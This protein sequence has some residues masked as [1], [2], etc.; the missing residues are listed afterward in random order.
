MAPP[1]PVNSLIVEDWFNGL[2]TAT[3]LV[4][5]WI[6]ISRKHYPGS[7]K[8]WQIM[9]VL[10]SYICSTMHSSLNWLYY[11][12]AIDDNELP[13][14][15]GL[16][17]SLT[18]LKV[19]IEGTGD[20]FFCLNIFMADCLFVWRC[21]I[22]WNR[23]WP[24]VVL[25]ILATLSGAVLAGFIVSDQVTALKSLEAFTVAKKSQQFVQLSTIY[26]SL[27]V[28][29]SL[30]TTFLITL[31][32][33]LVQRMSKKTGT[34]SH[35]SFN[36]I[37]EI[38]VESAVLYSVSLLTFVVL[39]VKKDINVYYA[40]N[41]HAQMAGLAPLLIILRVSAGKSR[42]QEDWST[43]NSGTLKFAPSNST[44]ANSTSNHD[45]EVSV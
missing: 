1:L 30:T 9:L 27:S 43:K 28:A 31:R 16:L 11:S 24:V 25:P 4:T 32:I 13:T 34:G 17:Y 44:F 37:M 3:M 8:K 6:I 45:A 15:P 20:T 36:P 40:Q 5:L 18:H 38:L 23:Q 10:A 7:R 22:V 2:Y 12:E 21:W 39:D 42:P 26:F 29:T 14:G 35:R 33:L 19:W 41:I